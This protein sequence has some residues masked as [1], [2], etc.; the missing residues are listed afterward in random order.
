M[1]HAR[2]AL[3][4]ALC[5]LAGILLGVNAPGGRATPGVSRPPTVISVDT[6]EPL[7]LGALTSTLGWRWTGTVN[8][9]DGTGDPAWKVA[10][11]AREWGSRTGLHTQVVDKVAAAQIVVYQVD[12][13]TD[14]GYPNA[15][16]LTYWPHV[17]GNVA[18][19]Q[20]RIEL[21]K[22]VADTYPLTAEDAAIHEL[23]HALGLAHDTVDKRTVMAPSIQLGEGFTHPLAADYKNLQSIYG[24]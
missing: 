18:D 10:E 8:V 11:A 21:L 14:P 17:S 2:K 1:R 15:I 12:Q 24:R 7:T 3:I 16:G 19:G 4:A 22:W 9:Y 20:C 5:L 6:P 23:G 13:F